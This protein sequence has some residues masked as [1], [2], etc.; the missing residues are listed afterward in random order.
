MPESVCA[1]RAHA[2]GLLAWLEEAL[3]PLPFA[4][5]FSAAEERPGGI[6]ALPN[7]FLKAIVSQRYRDEL[8]GYAASASGR[9]FVA[10]VRALAERTGV[11]TSQLDRAPTGA[12]RKANLLHDA[13]VLC[14]R[15]LSS[16]R[17]A[18]A[19][20]YLESRHPPGACRRCRGRPHARPQ[21]SAA[22]AHKQ[23]LQRRR[24]R[25]RANRRRPTLGG[26]DLRRLARRAQ[27]R[28]HSLGASHP[29]PNRDETTM[30]AQPA[31]RGEREG[32][33]GRPKAG[34]R[35]QRAD[36]LCASLA[37][38]SVHFRGHDVPV[39]QIHERTYARWGTPGHHERNGTVGLGCR[40][41]M[42]ARLPA[43]CVTFRCPDDSTCRIA[44][45][46]DT[47]P[48]RGSEPARENA[49]WRCV[50]PRVP[51]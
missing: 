51:G 36:T 46:N 28:P 41:T 24:D 33:Q 14:R 30:A 7:G 23:R 20:A 38:T 35:W 45:V 32:C 50:D 26:T 16:D 19:R 3:R 29:A 40:M 21:P 39:C 34:R 17:G 8:N 18:T 27:S 12:E 1:R 10:T 13:F 47:T 11:E 9:N 49:G 15:E 2:S 44:T 31:T 43:C 22:G 25:E 5:C 48:P 42:L 6:L 37:S 4:M